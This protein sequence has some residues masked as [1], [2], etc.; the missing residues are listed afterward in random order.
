MQVRLND[1]WSLNSVRSSLF[2]VPPNGKGCEGRKIEENKTTF[3]K[4]RVR[5]L[6]NYILP[7]NQEAITWTSMP[8][9]SVSLRIFPRYELLETI[10]STEPFLDV[11]HTMI[12]EVW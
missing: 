8:V 7:V 10:Q 1:L 9:L 2:L 6:R 11:A 3:G 4:H 5:E 12:L